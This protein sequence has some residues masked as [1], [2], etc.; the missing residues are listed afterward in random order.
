MGLFKK[1]ARKSKSK[2]D[3]RPRKRMQ[4][5]RTPR[6]PLFKK[7]IRRVKHGRWPV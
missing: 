7:G 1:L 6:T 5:S 4:R 3:A 2:I